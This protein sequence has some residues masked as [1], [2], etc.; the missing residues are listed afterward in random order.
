MTTLKLMVLYPV[1]TDIQQFEN[2]YAEHLALFHRKMGVPLENVP[3]TVTK[4]LSDSAS[5]AAYYQMFSMAFASKQALDEALSSPQMAEV[6]ND[7]SRIS[8]GGAPV[9]LI[10]NES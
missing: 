6:A 4:F 9:M 1:P 5:P 8:S 10:G 3:Y 7:A 2:D